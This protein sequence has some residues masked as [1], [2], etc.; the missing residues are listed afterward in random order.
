MG[1]RLRRHRTDRA[2]P[3]MK[4]ARL[5][6]VW[7]GAATLPPIGRAVA[8]GTLARPD[9]DA[10]AVAYLPLGARDA[11]LL[12]L[13]KTLSG[14]ALTC[15]TECPMCAVQLEFT[16]SIETLLGLDK[17]K[18]EGGS[19]DA[20]GTR[21]TFR[22]PSSA[23]LEAAW[24]SSSPETFNDRL[25]QACLDA[26]PSDLAPATVD[27]VIAA[28]EA[29]DPLSVIWLDLACVA[30]GH[31]WRGV[32]DIAVLLWQELDRWASTTLAE[33]A[34]L[35]RTYGWSEAEILAMSPTRRRRYRELA[36]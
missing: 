18:A 1:S 36:Q 31:K 11:A 35:S 23:D 27:R 7:E 13:R 4:P 33:I 3:L 22:S 14:D 6:E 29:A 9:L 30:C 15:L 16:L 26:A 21:L 25:L 8:L 28:I 17:G 10:H 19:I 20:D 34:H 24:T 2:V 5:L 32:L 12:R